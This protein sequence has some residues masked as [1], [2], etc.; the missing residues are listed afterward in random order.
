MKSSLKRETGASTGVEFLTIKA[1]SS[2]CSILNKEWKQYNL[3]VTNV[4]KE[5]KKEEVHE[6]N[7]F[8]SGNSYN[9]IEENDMPEATVWLLACHF[10]F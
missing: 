4:Y 10:I 7:Y 9:D 5:V 2:S 6:T 1:S 3:Y 8:I